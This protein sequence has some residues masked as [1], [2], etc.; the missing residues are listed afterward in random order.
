VK[1]AT[2]EV[3]FLKEEKELGENK[4]KKL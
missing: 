2:I 4:W 3:F 1:S